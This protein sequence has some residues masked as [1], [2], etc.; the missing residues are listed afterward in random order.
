MHGGGPRDVKMIVNDALLS[1]AKGRDVIGLGCELN[2]FSDRQ[3]DGP[4]RD[5]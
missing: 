4:S 3:L 2:D 5:A 1:S